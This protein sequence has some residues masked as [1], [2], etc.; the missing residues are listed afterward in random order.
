MTGIILK[1]YIMPIW[2]IDFMEKY[3]E[4]SI[5]DALALSKKHKHMKVLVAVSDLEQNDVADFVKRT[6][7]ECENIIQE[8]QT[9]ARVCDDFIDS[10]RCFSVKQDLKRIR[11]VG[12]MSTILIQLE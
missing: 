8:A 2:G 6:K 9:V 7:T 10:L 1:K 12:K 11:P 3:I 5:D 4:M